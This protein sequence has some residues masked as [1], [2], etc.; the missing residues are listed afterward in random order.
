M[1]QEFA[2]PNG[3]EVQ[4]ADL[5]L[6]AREAARSAD[7][8][9]AQLLRPSTPFGPTT[10]VKYVIPGGA[11]LEKVYTGANQRPLITSSAAADSKV[12]IYPFLAIVG[13]LDVATINAK[14]S[15]RNIRSVGHYGPDNGAL[16]TLLQFAASTN[17]RWDLVYAKI[18]IDVLDVGTVRY[19]KTGDGVAT[20]ATV[21]KTKQTLLSLGVVQGAESAGVATRPSLPADSASTYYIAL[22]YVQIDALWTTTSQIADYMIHEIYETIGLSTALGGGQLKPVNGAYQV[23]GY[24]VTQETWQGSSGFR[25]KSYLP[26]GMVGKEERIV[27]LHARDTGHGN[28]SVP[29]NTTVLIDD[30]IDWRRRLFKTTS[31][32][33][34]AVGGSNDGFPWALSPPGVNL[35][36]WTIAVGDDPAQSMRPGNSFQENMNAFTSGAITNGA[37]VA[38]WNDSTF[39][40][41]AAGAQMALYV[42]LATGQLKCWRNN[43]N[44]DRMILAWLEATGP[45]VNYATSPD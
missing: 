29:I 35:S 13:S 9:L 21:Q 26:P 15:L 23:G 7:W 37:I 43:V 24:V 27:P 34:G 11:R 40:V 32:Q 8:L 19:V 12:R 6:V 33:A 3:V 45:F 38:Y 17:K 42:D 36:N 30:S 16:R 44:A 1:E 25:P 5:N 2:A 28:P 18:D 31:Y 22:A 41:L 10:P 14:D 20:T 39:P 4:V